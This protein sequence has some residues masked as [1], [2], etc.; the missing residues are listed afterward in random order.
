MRNLLCLGLALA[1]LF[2]FAFTAV[3]DDA[4]NKAKKAP[5]V[6]GVISDVKAG[7]DKD[8]GEITLTIQKKAKKGETAPEPEKKTIKV[9]EATKVE[10]VSGKKGETTTTAGSFKDLKNGEH[11]SVTLDG[12]TAKD[13]TIRVKA[14]K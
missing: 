9:A 7:T 10:L 2:A 14:K 4:K 1:A 11:V 13:I 6:A 5:K 3:A 8:T 12:D